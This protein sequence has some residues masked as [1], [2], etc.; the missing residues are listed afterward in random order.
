MIGSSH[1]QIKNERFRL[2][3]INLKTV[4]NELEKG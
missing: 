2:E 4:I 1:H 3:I